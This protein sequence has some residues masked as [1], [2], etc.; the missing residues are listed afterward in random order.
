MPPPAEAIQF[1]DRMRV[2]EKVD[3]AKR[4]LDQ[5]V[6]SAPPGGAGEVARS[7]SY[8]QKT[9]GVCGGEACI[10]RTRVPVWVLIRHMQ[11]GHTESDVLVDYPGLTRAD[12]DAAWAYYR[13]NTAE[14]EDVIAAQERE[15]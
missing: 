8:V 2:A 10:R 14:V 13:D 7:G 12:L 11:I 5:V 15:D 4:L 6:A 1:L 3:L 9:P